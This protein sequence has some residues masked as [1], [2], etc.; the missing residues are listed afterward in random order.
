MTA[1]ISMV[2]GLELLCGT[3]LSEKV[4]SFKIL[5]KAYKVE[6]RNN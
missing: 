5:Y 4:R 3:T 1:Y 2:Q 6:S